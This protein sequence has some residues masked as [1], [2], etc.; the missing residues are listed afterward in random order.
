MRKIL[1]VF[2]FELGYQ[3]R[4]ASTLVYFLLA[5]GLCIAFAQ[6]MSGGTRDDGNFNSPFAATVTVVFGSMLALVIIAGLAGD[7]AARD[8]D[9]RLDSLFYTSPVG[10]P[11]YV[12]GRFLG[13][14]AVSA[15][16]LLALPAGSLA[17]TWMPWVDPATLGP[18]RASAYLTP[19]FLF[20]LPNAFVA[21]AV[22]FSAAALTRRAMA[23]YGAAAFLF[24]SAVIC[25]KLLGPRLGLGVASVLDPLGFTT[26]EA[27]VRSLNPLQKNTFVLIL[28][29]ALL[30]NRLLWLGIAATALAAAYARF[31]FAHQAV[32][33]RGAAAAPGR[34]SLA[35]Q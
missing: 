17:A 14:L 21:T 27:L 8:T 33:S 19:Y 35:K 26:V 12:L 30:T 15:L 18:F 25:A 3:L 20:A 11:A 24:F 5:L 7:A 31:R 34:R 9:V 29:S 4:R 32:G 10:K 28:D 1:E 22:L 23:S 2:R 16:L 13:A 6:M